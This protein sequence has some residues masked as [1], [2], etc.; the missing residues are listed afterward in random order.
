MGAAKCLV[1]A[2]GPAGSAPAGE[3]YN[4][5][6]PMKLLGSPASPYT[7]KVR[8]VLA[9]KRIEC[10][11]ELVDVQPAENPV[12]AHNPL[13]KIPTLLLDDGSAL[14]NSRVTGHFLDARSPAPP[15]RARRACAPRPSQLDRHMRLLPGTRVRGSRL[16][17]DAA[18]AGLRTSR[19]A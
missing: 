10:E 19:H 18:P 12:N 14:Y 5:A 13:G 6:L 9:E 16:R 7:R 1:H 15:P 2:R 11:M 8:L 4:R 17:P 3:S